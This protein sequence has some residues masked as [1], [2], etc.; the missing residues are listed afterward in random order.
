MIL[1]GVPTIDNPFFAT[2]TTSFH[3]LRVP[4]SQLSALVSHISLTQT[5]L[6]TLVLPRTLPYAYPA[7]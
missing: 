5:P 1:P 6:Y 3:V 7:G 4:S 2:F